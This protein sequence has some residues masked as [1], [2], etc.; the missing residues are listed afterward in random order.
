MLEPLAG[1][2]VALWPLLALIAALAATVF[3]YSRQSSRLAP[4][5]AEARG[6]PAAC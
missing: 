3:I 4:E 2:A 5:A 6:E 1:Q